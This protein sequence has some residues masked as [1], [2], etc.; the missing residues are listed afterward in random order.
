MENSGQY[1]AEA[2][3]YI[4]AGM[5]ALSMLGA[6]LGVSNI[7]STIITTVGRNPSVKG[8]VNLYAWAG[9]AVTEAIALY[10]LVIA[11]ITIYA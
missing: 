11:L 6:A 1:I 5:C 7:W 10:A 2:A 4:G 9:F 8:D 3:K